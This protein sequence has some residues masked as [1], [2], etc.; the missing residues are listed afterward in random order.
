MGRRGGGPAPEIARFNPSLD[1]TPL[2][3]VL[4]LF[5]W[6]PRFFLLL[7][8]HRFFQRRFLEVSRVQSRNDD[9]IVFLKLSVMTA[10][11]PDCSIQPL[12]LLRGQ[13]CWSSLKMQ[14][15]ARSTHSLRA[16]CSYTHTYVGTSAYVSSRGRSCGSEQT[17]EPFCSWTP[18]MHPVSSAQHGDEPAVMSH[19]I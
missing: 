4:K 8:T 9:I 1:M 15:A 6:M 19:W 12:D 7:P 3:A 5:Q 11:C 16:F 10:F 18:Y 17:L 14:R 13:I 2:P